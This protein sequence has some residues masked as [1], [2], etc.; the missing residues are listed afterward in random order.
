MV[1]SGSASLKTVEGKNERQA[2]V[3]HRHGQ[4]TWNFSLRTQTFSCSVET[5]WL[6]I[7]KNQYKQQGDVKMIKEQKKAVGFLWTASETLE[8]VRTIEPFSVCSN[9][10]WGSKNTPLPSES[11]WVQGQV[12]H[13]LLPNTV[14]L[15]RHRAQ[16]IFA[17][18]QGL[19]SWNQS[20][21]WSTSMGFV[22][23]TILTIIYL[24][25]QTWSALLVM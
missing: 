11:E 21:H 5:K 2:Y 14:P 15:S 10:W 8:R 24:H 9:L 12:W 25:P 23:H 4:H 17:V 20:N 3:I 18:S 16:A 7:Q 13:L 6:I 22:S 1:W 19:L